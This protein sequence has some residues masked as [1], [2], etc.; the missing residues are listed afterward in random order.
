MAS[1]REKRLALEGEARGDT[2][3]TPEEDKVRVDPERQV[4]LWDCMYVFIYKYMY[5]CTQ[6]Y[7][8]MHVY[9]IFR[10]TD[11][12]LQSPRR[13]TR[14]RLGDVRQLI[15]NIVLFQN[16]FLDFERGAIFFFG[17]ESGREPFQDTALCLS[18]I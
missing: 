10:G 13:L 11:L 7:G 2:P 18:E 12:Y 1:V 14:L 4:Y 6:V 15:G 5:M 9:I 17:L 8:C 16:H 3:P